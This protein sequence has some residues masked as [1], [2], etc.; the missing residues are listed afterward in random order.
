MPSDS[1]I[2]IWNNLNNFNLA[3]VDYGYGCR[4]EAFIYTDDVE[5][6]YTAIEEGLI[7]AGYTKS[8][9]KTYSMSFKKVLNGETVYIFVLK[10]PDKG[11][12]RFMHGV[13]GM[14]FSR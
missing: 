11:Y 4:D 8:Y 10:E 12:V 14:D 3:K 1:V 2:E 7:A 9:S 6:A 5:G 13:G